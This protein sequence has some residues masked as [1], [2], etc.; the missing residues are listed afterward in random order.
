M[1]E[2]S[3]LD[4]GDIKTAMEA[5]DTLLSF[6][7]FMPPHGLLVMILG[8]FRD[9]LRDVLGLEELR[10]AVRGNQRRALA[11]LRPVELTTL[12]GALAVLRQPRFTNI[13]DDPDLPMLLAGFAEDVSDHQARLAALADAAPAEAQAS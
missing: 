13:M 6:R 11:D 8:K 12:A 7:D 9:D 2:T 5:A 3:H 1:R 10:R 4:S